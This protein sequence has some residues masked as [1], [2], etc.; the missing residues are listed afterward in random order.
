MSSANHGWTHESRPFTY[1]CLGTFVAKGG[2]Q[3][4]PSIM[5]VLHQN[6]EDCCIRILLFHGCYGDSM[7]SAPPHLCLFPPLRS[8]LDCST[9]LTVKDISIVLIAPN[10]HKH[11]LLGN[12]PRIFFFFYCL[13]M[14]CSVCFTFAKLPLGPLFTHLQMYQVNV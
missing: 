6:R 11:Y 2:A 12:V 4:E 5:Q 13:D 14:V 8:D 7:G 3:C 10:G 1:R 9:G